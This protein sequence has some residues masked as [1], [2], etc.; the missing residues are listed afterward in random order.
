MTQ[1]ADTTAL[2][3]FSAWRSFRDANLDAWSKLMIEIVNSEAYAEASAR[4]LESTLATSAP[5][6][7]LLESTMTQA[8]AQLNMPSRADVISVAERLVNIERRLDDLEAR[9]D[10]GVVLPAAVPQPEP[11]TEAQ[12]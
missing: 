4:V 5:Y 9:L 3:P 6:R 10:R 7:K 8:L 2:D 1:R 11:P 12:S